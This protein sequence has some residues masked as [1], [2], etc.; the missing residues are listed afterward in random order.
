MPQQPASWSSA[1]PDTAPSSCN[2]IAHAQRYSVIRR[3][4][5]YATAPPQKLASPHPTLAEA[6]DHDHPAATCLLCA[7]EPLHP[8]HDHRQ[9]GH[10]RRAR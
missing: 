4:K 1:S 8:C 6:F 10:A 5:I 9:H 7:R 2:H 3:E